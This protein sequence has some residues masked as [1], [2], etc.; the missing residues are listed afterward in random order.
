[1]IKRPWALCVIFCLF[2]DISYFQD[3]WRFFFFAV[4]VS[5]SSF[6]VRT[7]FPTLLYWVKE[8]VSKNECSTPPL[9]GSFFN[10]EQMLGHLLRHRVPIYSEG[11]QKSSI[12]STRP[13]P[14]TGPFP[15]SPLS[16]FWSISAFKCPPP[17]HADCTHSPLPLL[18]F[19]WCFCFPDFLSPIFFQHPR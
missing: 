11:Q 6:M 17:Q 12:N 3:H 7:D 13:G 2:S 5:H 10:R 9:R 19:T 8:M 15:T 1:M 16:T 14:P 4:T 18:S